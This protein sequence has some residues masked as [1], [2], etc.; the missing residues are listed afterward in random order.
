MR[1]LMRIWMIGLAMAWSGLSTAQAAP[2]ARAAPARRPAAAP[3]NAADAALAE[4]SRQ[5]AAGQYD[6][7]LVAIDAGLKLDAKHT[8]LLELKGQV[9]VKLPD[10][11]GALEAYE[12]DLAAGPTGPNLRNARLQ[13][14]SLL[15]VRTTFLQVTVSQ[16][17]AVIHLG[18]RTDRAFCKAEPTCR[19]GWLPGTYK[20]FAERPGFMP[21]IGRV[22][23]IADKTVSLAIPLVEK[24]SLVTVR[25]AQADATVMVDDTAYT[26]PLTL[27]AGAHKVTVTL[28]GHV[29]AATEVIAR[30]GKPV[31]L[32]V[33]LVP[34]VPVVIEPATATATAT[35][36][37]D[38]KPVELHDGG[39]GI[40]SGAHV[41]VAR[42]RGFRD[43]RVEIPA[44]RPADYVARVE[45]RVPE[46]PRVEPSP[47]TTR[48]KIALAAG[49][50]GLAALAGGAV[51]GTQ[52][53][54]R[55]DDAFALCPSPATPCAAAAP[56][57]DL[58]KQARS[59]ALQ[60][61]IA[62]GVAAGAVIAA[63]ILWLTGAPESPEPRVAIT[64]HVDGTVAGLDLAL[65][66]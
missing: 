17:P 59:R 9:L 30:E 52:A 63:S 6:E 64:P 25:A 2:G 26:A 24:P 20:V 22:T 8:G 51:L 49:G 19:A 5:V 38:D 1:G 10:Y 28:P 50:V 12:A 46:P 23:L 7:A 21:W 43:G 56:A 18:S 58:N 15:P 66:F 3:A 13:V 47:F 34:R 11:L 57:N 33:T 53:K 31:E 14:K 37:L 65:R 42:A 40:P 27:P 55:E 35:L 45:L 61:N 44:A 60:A 39:V 48:R 62:Y 41:L 29:P 4:A 16:G 54:Q 36:L 32:D